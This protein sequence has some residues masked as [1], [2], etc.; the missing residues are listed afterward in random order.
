M[1]LSLKGDQGRVLVSGNDCF[2]VKFSGSDG[3]RDIELWADP[4]HP[5]LDFK[6]SDLIDEIG[7]AVNFKLSRHAADRD[8]SL[9]RRRKEESM[10]IYFDLRESGGTPCVYQDESGPIVME[11]DVAAHPSVTEE[12]MKRRAEVILLRRGMMLVD[13]QGRMDGHLSLWDISSQ[14]I[15]EGVI[16]EAVDAGDALGLAACTPAWP[17]DF[18]PADILYALK[19]DLIEVL[20]GNVYEG[21]VFDAKEFIDFGPRGR[22][23]GRIEFAKDIAQFANSSSG[24]LMLIGA[25]TKKLEGGAEVLEKVAP[26]DKNPRVESVRKLAQAARGVAR[27]H[28]YPEVSKLSIEVISLRAGEV[29]CVHIPPQSSA[30]KPFIVHGENISDKYFGEFFSVPRRRGDGNSALTVREIHGLLS[31]KSWDLQ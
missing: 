1:T 8:V 28:I 12:E 20:L 18:T 27:E 21:E 15:S 16:Q 23:E 9:S 31:V 26:L 25:K 29:V 10:T 5:P 14:W 6:F 11:F 24:G 2:T 22:G 19:H 30:L 3:Q 13:L 17:T 7:P 4:G